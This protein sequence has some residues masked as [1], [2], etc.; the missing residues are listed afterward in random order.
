MGG[1]EGEEEGERG[2][3]GRFVDEIM[4]SLGVFGSG[5]CLQLLTKEE[6]REGR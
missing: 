5:D 3:V 6:K 2:R 4:E 1:R